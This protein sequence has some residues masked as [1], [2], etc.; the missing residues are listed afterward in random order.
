VGNDFVEM[1][2]RFHPKIEAQD[3][4][5]YIVGFQTDA[6]ASEQLEAIAGV[7][8][9]WHKITMEPTYLPELLTQTVEAAAARRA[10]AAPEEPEAQKPKLAARTLRSRPARWLILAAIV[11]G[12]ILMLFM[13]KKRKKEGQGGPDGEA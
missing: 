3:T 11:L 4:N 9:G 7:A 12:G 1:E 8:G 2:M 13:F 10:P 6:S 5:F